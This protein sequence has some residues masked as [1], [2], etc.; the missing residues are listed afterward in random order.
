MLVWVSA[1]VS[2]YSLQ[3][4]DLVSQFLH[5][6]YNFLYI[7]Q[8]AY[9]HIFTGWCVS[10]LICFSL[11]WFLCRAHRQSNELTRGPPELVHI[12]AESTTCHKFHMVCLY[13]SLIPVHGEEGSSFH[14][15]NDFHLASLEKRIY[16][17][18]LCFPSH[19]FRADRPFAF[20]IYNW[21][22]GGALFLGK[23]GNPTAG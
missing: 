8:E 6:L 19:V 5:V 14:F 9:F 22:L 21:R 12:G 13:R 18:R 11:M 17:H 4:F 23:V 7:L 16:P 3:Y 2:L 15:Q 20:V 10:P 1:F